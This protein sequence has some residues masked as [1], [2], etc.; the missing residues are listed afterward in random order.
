MPGKVN[1]VIPEAVTMVAAQII[2]HDVTIS[3]A[4]LN[5][6]LDL[7]VMMP[8]IAY[9]LLQSVALAT[10]AIRILAEKCVAGITA[11]VARCRE[12]AEKSAA[13]VT[14]VAPAI[15]YDNA[16]RMF[17]KALA[18]DKSI[19]QVLREEGILA[20]ERID[21]ILDLKKLSTGGRMDVA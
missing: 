12:Y 4:A 10:N 3:V 13:L 19:R 6:N 8:S 20:E 11:N 2:G 17:K 21:E 14:A 7:N 5:G 1:P 15:G 16:A 9:A 18:E